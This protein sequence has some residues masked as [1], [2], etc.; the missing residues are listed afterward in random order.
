MGVLELLQGDPPRAHPQLGV[1]PTPQS[2]ASRGRGGGAGGPFPCLFPCTSPGIPRRCSLPSIPGD[3]PRPAQVARGHVAEKGLWPLL[4]SPRPQPTSETCPGVSPP[5]LLSPSLQG[6]ATTCLA[7]DEGDGDGRSRI[8]VGAEVGDDLLARQG[9]TN[10]QHL[11]SPNRSSDDSSIGAGPSPGAWRTWGVR[12]QERLG[13][14]RLQGPPSPLL[15]GAP[16]PEDP[17]L[18]P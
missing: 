18:C 6:G 5:R 14:G 17:G 9:S 4:G 13:C 11:F 1:R 8:P 15:R 3:L 10:F 7:Q 2:H 12:P 16:A